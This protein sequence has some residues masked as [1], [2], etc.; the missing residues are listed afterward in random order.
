MAEKFDVQ[1]SVNIQYKNKQVT[2]E[3]ILILIKPYGIE[4][5]LTIAM[6]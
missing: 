6:K 2:F 5:N 3:I 4:E 1:M